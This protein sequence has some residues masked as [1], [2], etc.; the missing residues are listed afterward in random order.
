MNLELLYQ[1]I[2][3]H[4]LSHAHSVLP[5]EHP[6]L[7]FCLLPLAK[8]QLVYQ[9]LQISFSRNLRWSRLLDS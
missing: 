4:A 9:P 3:L 5:Q 1:L 2:C 6:F 8:V 7:L